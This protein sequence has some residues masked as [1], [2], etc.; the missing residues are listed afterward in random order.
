MFEQ[1][2]IIKD[3]HA[4]AFDCILRQSV[5]SRQ[6]YIIKQNKSTMIFSNNSTINLP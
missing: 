5:A 4:N 1:Y 2:P 6:L 3:V